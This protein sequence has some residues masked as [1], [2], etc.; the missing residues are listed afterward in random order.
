MPD[1]PENKEREFFRNRFEYFNS[2]PDEKVWK[3]VR[4]TI[5]N[6]YKTRWRLVAAVTALLGIIAS[7]LVFQAD[8]SV[9]DAR[10]VAVENTGN[11]SKADPD[12]EKVQSTKHLS[13]PE[14]QNF[15][16]TAPGNQNEVK[17]KNTEMKTTGSEKTEGFMTE[18]K[19][20]LNLKRKTP[21]E[22]NKRSENKNSGERKAPEQ[23]PNETTLFDSQKTN[24]NSL[25]LT[26]GASNENI[27]SDFR[28]KTESSR[29]DVPENEDGFTK[30]INS[31]KNI[32]Y[33]TNT[34]PELM[35]IIPADTLTAQLPKDNP[36]IVIKPRSFSSGFRRWH[37]S[38]GFMPFAGYYRISPVRSDS[39]FV[40]EMQGGRL[41]QR[42]GWQAQVG[43]GYALTPRW[44]LRASL[45][46]NHLQTYLSYQT[47]NIY[48]LSR[49]VRM[50]NSENIEVSQSFNDRTFI[51][52]Y[53]QQ[54]FGVR[55]EM[56]YYLSPKRNVQRYVSGGFYTDK[57]SDIKDDLYMQGSYGI[58]FPLYRRFRLY[59]EPSLQWSVNG[60]TDKRYYTTTRP[61]RIGINIGVTW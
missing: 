30:N 51:Q 46:Y 57:L 45:V 35:K 17:Q 11:K 54:T 24:E 12:K 18:H 33:N 41:E 2:E 49:E 10:M 6:S 1:I 4:K 39:V 19:T 29:K 26:T 47:Q 5:D 9:S 25:S 32:L 37:L 36:L 27:S 43:V 60:N 31:E 28:K 56:L 20:A 7:L 15:P 38:I 50:I 8:L 42:L 23:I 34:P 14:I 13:E 59:V 21:Q 55:T 58:R 53:Q 61:Y 22:T 44:T 52:T 48:P 3:N 16:E 40:S